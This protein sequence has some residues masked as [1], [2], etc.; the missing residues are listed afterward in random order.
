MIR[1]AIAG[2]RG[3]MGMEAV[4]TVM[5]NECMELVAVLDY[6]QVGETLAEI[7]NPALGVAVREHE[8]ITLDAGNV[9]HCC[10]FAS[11]CVPL[12]RKRGSGQCN[13]AT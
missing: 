4:H 9:G 6:K 12:W 11:L 3:K 1:V 5:K 2:A 7:C 10:L 13:F 8:K